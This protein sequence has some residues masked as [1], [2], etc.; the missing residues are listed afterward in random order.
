MPKHPARARRIADQIQRELADI[1]RLDL[2]DP[3]VGL[4]TLTD[5]DVTSDYSHAKVFFTLLNGQASAEDV[6]NV[7]G[8]AAGFLRSQLAHR[9]K[10]RIVP[11]LHFH[12]D[13]SVERGR[14]LSSLIE[15][16]VAE[17]NARDDRRQDEDG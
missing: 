16:A 15:Q 17:D 13:V 5:V 7:L 1:L 11:V 4:I 2:R 12:Y 9:M 3:R 10:L 6:L 8:Q 14:T